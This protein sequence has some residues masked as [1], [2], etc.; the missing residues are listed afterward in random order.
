METALIENKYTVSS[1]LSM[2]KF[3]FIFMYTLFSK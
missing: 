3:R 2:I 1:L